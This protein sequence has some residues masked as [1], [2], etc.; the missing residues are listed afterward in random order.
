MHYYRNNPKY[1]D[2]QTW[3]NIVDSGQMSHEELDQTSLQKDIK[4]SIH[5]NLCFLIF[6]FKVN[7]LSELYK[8]TNILSTHNTNPAW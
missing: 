6:D 1:W 3:A 2:R 4:N 7:T 5:N 8:Q